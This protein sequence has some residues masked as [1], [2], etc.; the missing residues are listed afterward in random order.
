M[1]TRLIKSGLKNV[2][3]FSLNV[4]NYR[5][6]AQENA[7]AAK[8]NAELRKKGAKTKPF[9]VDTSRNGKGPG[10]DWCNPAGRKLGVTSRVNKTPTAKTPEARLWVKTPGESDGNCGSAPHAAA[11]V[12]DPQIAVNLVKGK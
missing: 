9:I 6:T 1:S 5:T 2:R 4:S 10:S 8:V 11:G 7:Y 12:F 3:G